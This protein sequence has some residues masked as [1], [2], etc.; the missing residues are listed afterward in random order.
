MAFTKIRMGAGGILVDRS[1]QVASD[2]PVSSA[3]TASTGA[4]EQV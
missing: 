1:I 3:C 4:D 2:L